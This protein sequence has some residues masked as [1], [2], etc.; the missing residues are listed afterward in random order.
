LSDLL[1]EPIYD[2]AVAATFRKRFDL[3]A[4]L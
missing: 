3:P 4:G 1:D 2:S